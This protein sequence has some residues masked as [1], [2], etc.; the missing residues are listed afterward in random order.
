MIGSPG[1]TCETIEETIE[2]AKKLDPDFVQFSI[3]TPYP[4]TELYRLSIEEGGVPKQWSKYVY[5]DLKPDDSPAFETKNLKRQELREWNKKAYTSFYLRW[6]YASKRLAKM[7]S[8]GEL[9]TNF[10]GLR[11]LIDLVK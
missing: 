6:A 7:T 9:R 8:P 11:M 3:A 5:A 2:F 10:A 1:E 4:G